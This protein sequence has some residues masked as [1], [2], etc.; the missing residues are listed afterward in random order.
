MRR[1]PAPER[2]VVHDTNFRARAPHKAPPR[3]AFGVVLKTLPHDGQHRGHLRRDHSV[4]RD[5]EESVRIRHR[6]RRKALRLAPVSARHHDVQRDLG[7]DRALRNLGAEHGV[8]LWS[9]ARHKR[10][11][12]ADGVRGREARDANDAALVSD[13]NELPAQARAAHEKGAWWEGVW[14]GFAI[15]CGGWGSNPNFRASAST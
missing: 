4:P 7:L 11:K 14:A 2:L 9:G 10:F 6:A 15:E 5:R 13:L 1:A 8:Q 3:A 12:V